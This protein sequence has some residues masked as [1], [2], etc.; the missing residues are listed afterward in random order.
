MACPTGSY[1]TA[2]QMP[3]RLIIQNDGNLVYYSRGNE[4]MW[5][6]NT[7]VSTGASSMLILG[8]SANDGTLTLTVYD[9]SRNQLTK[10]LYPSS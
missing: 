4:A 3:G 10:T 5:A 7:G 6:T 8:G 9:Y 2:D 1:P